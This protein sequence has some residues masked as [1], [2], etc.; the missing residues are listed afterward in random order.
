MLELLFELLKPF[1][2]KKEEGCAGRTLFVVENCVP[3]TKAFQRMTL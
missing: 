1:K 2:I 3:E